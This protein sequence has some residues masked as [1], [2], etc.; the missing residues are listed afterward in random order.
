VRARRF[1][2]SVVNELKADVVVS[3]GPWVHVV[4]GQGV[5]KD[6]P[7]AFFLH[8][9]VTGD[10]LDRLAGLRPPEVVFTNSEYSRGT[11]RRAF[12][13]SPSQVV[14]CVLPDRSAPG[15]RETARSS[16]GV[17]SEIVLLQVSRLERW[18]GHTLL[19]DALA[20]L[21]VGR[22]WTLWIA[23]GPQR[24]TE[25]SYLEELRT[26]TKELGLGERVRF[27]GERT[28]IPELLSAADIF[29][30]PNL[31]PEPL[32]LSIVEALSAGVP[33]VSTRA[34]GPAEYLDSSCAFLLE[35]KNPDVLAK[36]LAALIEDEPLRLEM[37]KQARHVYERE[38]EP[39][40]CDLRFSEALGSLLKA[41]KAVT[42]A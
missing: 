1:A 19:L 10:W 33:V 14:R 3:H 35:E 2:G 15:E 37:G 23:G 26:R 41:G 11:I 24:P 16:M 9:P 28:D 7:I 40:V 31:E 39:T 38:F 17:R 12:P 27:L 8:G 36:G 25:A 34:G 13:G 6:V 30:Q 20:R 18:K 5:P 32:G 42:W 21:R 22:S 29:C 4:L